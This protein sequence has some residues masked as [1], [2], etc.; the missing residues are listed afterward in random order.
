M[1]LNSAIYRR[2]VPT[3]D[4]NTGLACVTKPET[5]VGSSVNS[6]MVAK[7]AHSLSLPNQGIDGLHYEVPFGEDSTTS[8]SLFRM[9]LQKHQGV[10]FLAYWTT[11]P[12]I[13]VEIETTVANMKL[14]IIE[15]VLMPC[16]VECIEDIEAVLTSQHQCISH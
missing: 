13:Q 7:D 11:L 8:A 6:P 3:S 12:V 14:E 2:D 1:L 4:D 5:A 9:Y 15:K 16:Q 10:V